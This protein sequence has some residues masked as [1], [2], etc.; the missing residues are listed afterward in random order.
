M[1]GPRLGETYARR[2][3]RKRE[4]FTRAWTVSS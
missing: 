3:P 2:T 4:D 1:A